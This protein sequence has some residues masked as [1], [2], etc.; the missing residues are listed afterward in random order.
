MVA[1][2][3]RDGSTFD[4]DAFFKFCEQQVGTGGMDRKWFPD[5]VRVVDSFDFT[6]TQKILVRNL[7]SAHFD[8]HKIQDPLYWRERGDS[9]FRPFL[10]AEFVEVREEFASS[11]RLGLLDH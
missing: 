5:F 1:L 7:K 10:V 2:K 4:A 9:S 8:P 11:E 6:G 3:M